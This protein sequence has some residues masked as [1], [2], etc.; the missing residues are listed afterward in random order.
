M[1]E[2]EEFAIDGEN[3]SRFWGCFLSFLWKES[4]PRAVP[5]VRVPTPLPQLLG[6]FSPQ[7]ERCSW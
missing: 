3:P 5:A 1:V 4:S 2:K 6:V 7:L